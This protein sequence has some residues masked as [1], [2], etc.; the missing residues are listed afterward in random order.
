MRRE[1]RRLIAALALVASSGA[2]AAQAA[3]QASRPNLSYSFHV[4]SAHPLGTF[5]SLSDANIHV[6]V[7]FT[8]RLGDLTY[9]KQHWNIKLFAGLNQF[10]AE[11]FAGF[12]HPRWI[13][14]S[15][16][17]QLVTA[18]SATGLRGYA[19]AGPGVY[20]PK[21]GATVGGF[22]AGLGLQMPVGG[23]FALEFGID[24]HQIQTKG[25]TRFA[26]VQLGVLFR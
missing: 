15:A 1:I 9:L 7:D 20:K 24:Y 26:T 6:D 10:T 22:N 19:Q 17:L 23:A 25:P 4:G 8:Y 21:S 16:N 5:D 14:L 13:N 12:E 3:A 11:S 2:V 18:P